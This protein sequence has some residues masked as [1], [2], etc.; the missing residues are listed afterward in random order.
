MD[1]VSTAMAHHAK[2]FG[3]SI[4]PQKK[5]L[6]LNPTSL[7]EETANASKP[8]EDAIQ[9]P[10]R[11]YDYQRLNKALVHLSEALA[12]ALQP[13][14]PLTASQPE[15]FLISTDQNSPANTL[16]KMKPY[17]ISNL[18]RDE[19]LRLN[20]TI[21]DYARLGTDRQKALSYALGKVFDKLLKAAPT[22]RFQEYDAIPA[23]LKL[24][25]GITPYEIRDK[26]QDS[27]L[28]YWFSRLGRDQ[29]KMLE[30]LTP[31]QI[32]SL[33]VH[34]DLVKSLSRE[35]IDDLK[36][37]QQKALREAALASLHHLQTKE[38]A[39]IPLEVI[40]WLNL[41]DAELR[42]FKGPTH[43]YRE[44]H[45]ADELSKAAQKAQ[46]LDTLPESGLFVNNRERA[47]LILD[48]MGQA[49]QALLK[50]AVNYNEELSLPN[51]SVTIKKSTTYGMDVYTFKDKH[52]QI[53]LSNMVVHQNGMAIGNQAYT[54]DGKP[55]ETKDLE[56]PTVKKAL[57]T[58]KALRAHQ[59]KTLVEQFKSDPASVKRIKIKDVAH[60]LEGQDLSGIDFSGADF[61]DVNLAAIRLQGTR[62]DAANF[63]GAVFK[64]AKL[65]GVDFKGARLQAAHLEDVD[66][67]GAKL[68]GAH[69]TGW[70][71][72]LKD[73]T[74]D[75]TRTALKGADLNGADFRDIVFK[76]VALD[77]VNFAG[78]ELGM[79]KLEGADFKGAQLGKAKLVS[80]F[81]GS[82][83]PNNLKDVK[84]QGADLNDCDLNGVTFEKVNLQGV[85]F[86]G[87][88]MKGAHFE[89]PTQKGS[90]FSKADF[91]NAIIDYRL[92]GVELYDPVTKRGADF[93][94]ATLKGDAVVKA[95]INQCNFKGTRFDNAVFKEV[96][97]K[98]VSFAGAK[99]KDAVFLW[100]AQKGADFSKADFTDTEINYKLEGVQ[101]YDP[102][103]GSG[104]D[105]SK[106]T[107]TRDAAVNADLRKCN[108]YGTK[109]GTKDTV[110][111][112]ENAKLDDNLQVFLLNQVNVDFSKT[113]LSKADK[114][115]F[116][117]MDG[118]D[119]RRFPSTLLA[120]LDLKN[121]S[122][123]NAILK[124]KEYPG[125]KLTDVDMSGVNAIKTNL[126]E[127][128][129]TRIKMNHWNKDR[130][131]DDKF[132]PGTN[133]SKAVLSQ[134]EANQAN[135]TKSD[136]SQSKLTDV[137]A[138]DA[139]FNDANMSEISEA[140]GLDVENATFYGADLSESVFK[141][142][143]ERT[144]RFVNTKF[145][146]NS[147]LQ[148]TSLPNAD[149]RKA[150]FDGTHMAWIML[151]GA[152]L[153]ETRFI[154]GAYMLGASLKEVIT[155][156]TTD[157][158]TANLYKANLSK[159]KLN[160]A[161]FKGANLGC[162]I[163]DN[164]EFGEADLRGA[165]LKNAVI[166][167]ADFSKIRFDADK[168]GPD[169]QFYRA[170]YDDKTKFPGID[171]NNPA[172]RQ[173]FIQR[174]GLIPIQRHID[175][176]NTYNNFGKVGDVPSFMKF[177]FADTAVNLGTL[178]K[179]G[180]ANRKESNILGLW[181]P[182]GISPTH[183]DEALKRLKD[184]PYLAE[185]LSQ[186]GASDDQIAKIVAELQKDKTEMINALEDL[187]AKFHCFDTN[188]DGV[189]NKKDLEQLAKNNK[190]AIYAHL[191]TISDSDWDIIAKEPE[192]A[193]MK[194]A[195]KNAPKRLFLTDSADVELPFV[196]NVKSMKTVFIEKSGPMLEELFGVKE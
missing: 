5:T 63:E 45:V 191:G 128:S 48:L 8:S 115:T 130:Y 100:P 17:D 164:T 42:E 146:R 6:A 64:G 89:W 90:D 127:G 173:D 12:G 75:L 153:I 133:F 97:L 79:A 40:S 82:L 155:D 25:M 84:F 154:N 158:S 145:D 142:S 20:V 34:P 36:P 55:V 134:I 102:I 188:N 43:S 195:Y 46:A 176:T 60:L 171:N 124:D 99:M 74:V 95:D 78:A 88:K 35:I 139:K 129:Y 65:K 22:L 37:E 126:S 184:Q 162:A 159:S 131:T 167:G 103:T 144:T 32:R 179:I 182:G 86:A 11:S 91:T 15:L 30:K 69:L 68:G 66:F 109:L 193:N 44:E 96:N 120:E 77:G 14:A 172:A 9:P 121:K 98:G 101:L 187:K 57:Q 125:L 117:N 62:L 26:E 58:A 119:F 94:K 116:K 112:F 178:P 13:T 150:T 10:H 141:S 28:S 107:F 166:T 4:A 106:A 85:S 73:V 157:F 168:I 24:L 71:K 27:Q 136:F 70:N 83:Q 80:Y 2:S 148:A 51:G 38:V 147:K 31:E 177:N 39:A 1:T 33:K 143:P 105:F 174:H 93:S 175:F 87:A 186:K 56:S 138:R 92:E 3:P 59:A 76:G 122:M 29:A 183:I 7:A 50:R 110:A 123:K 180:N 161:N 132:T 18:S 19:L 194:T 135:F 47:K 151:D 104:A 81:H 181:Q 61:S 72:D 192:G 67:N 23:P 165:K 114:K 16:G 21:E 118:V 49:Q 137:V 170:Y 113:D 41:T 152:N 108:L 190:E 163:L 140:I 53:L 169:S 189:F 185:I 196:G 54:L 149:L 111:N 160:G 156:K 52:G